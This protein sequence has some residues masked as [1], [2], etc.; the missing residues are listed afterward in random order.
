M[1]TVINTI[2][3]VLR[4]VAYWLFDQYGAGT[5]DF[6]EFYVQ[7]LISTCIGV[8]LPVFVLYARTEKNAQRLVVAA[9]LTM[10]LYFYISL[11]TTFDIFLMVLSGGFMIY[12]LWYKFLMKSIF[13]PFVFSIAIF[14]GLTYGYTLDFPIFLLIFVKAFLVS[15]MINRK[16]LAQDMR[17]SKCDE[18]G[19]PSWVASGGHP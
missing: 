9:F 19:R 12:F 14:W 11:E 2:S 4:S 10:G 6:T 5:A 16:K 15:V 1:E 13:I 17:K 18:Y 3:S 7:I 8:L